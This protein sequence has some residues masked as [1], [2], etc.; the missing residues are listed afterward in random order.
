MSRQVG[1]RDIGR[2]GVQPRVAP[3]SIPWNT[4]WSRPSGAAKCPRFTAPGTLISRA[5]NRMIR[6]L[7]DPVENTK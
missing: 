2:N 1:I 3:T 5:G 4:Y 7:V 6:R